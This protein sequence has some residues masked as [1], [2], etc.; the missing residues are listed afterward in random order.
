MCLVQVVNLVG[1]LDPMPLNEPFEQLYT[2]TA[3]PEVNSCA[4]EVR[5]QQQKLRHV[6][7][8]A[9]VGLEVGQLVKRKVPLLF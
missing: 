6:E 2:A 1:H 9:T 7:H 3:V 5:V 4:A 8:F